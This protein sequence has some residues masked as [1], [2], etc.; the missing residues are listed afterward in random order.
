MNKN[1]INNLAVQKNQGSLNMDPVQLQ[2]EQ[3]VGDRF[4]D[5]LSATSGAQCLFLRRAD[6]APDL[7]YSYRE[8]ELL[9]EITAAYYDGSHAA[10]LWKTARGAIDGPTGWAGENPDNLLAAAI[11]ER[12]IEK[13]MNRYGE[14]SVLLIEVPPGVTTAESLADLIVDQSLPPKTP[15]VGIFVVGNFPVTTYSMGGYRVIPI[16]PLPSA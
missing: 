10:F 16:K 5:W 15:F 7:V 13:S 4:A 3:G 11:G 14:N 1:Y 8:E 6:L 9:V 12:I 2:F